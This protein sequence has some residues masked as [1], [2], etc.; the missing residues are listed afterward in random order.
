MDNNIKKELQLKRIEEKH[1]E[2][3]LEWYLD[4]DFL[5]MYDYAEPKTKTI[6]ELRELYLNTDESY[7]LFG[8]FVEDKLIGISELYKISAKNK[9]AEVS[10]GLGDRS[11]WGKGYG[12]KA[13]KLTL[14]YGFNELKLNRIELE[15]I[16]YNKGAIALYESLGFKK[17]GT[18]RNRVKWEDKYYDLYLYGM[19]KN[20][21]KN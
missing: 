3:I 17:E 8:V 14:S 21:Y 2:T 15:V 11:E 20:E 12:K 18:K 5:H 16:G 9:C 13:I 1:L 19:L 4:V 7:E 6:K 10:I